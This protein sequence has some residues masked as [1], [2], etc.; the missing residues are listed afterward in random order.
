[1]LQGGVEG[2]TFA[3]VNTDVQASIAR[4]PPLKVL[5]GPKPAKRLG[6]GVNPYTA[7]WTALEDRDTIAALVKDAQTVIIVAGTGGGT[8][9]L[10][11]TEQDQADIEA[12]MMLLD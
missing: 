4:S 11:L 1:M 3:A 9:E 5:L 8:P 7:R 6:A 2:T 12:F 10:E